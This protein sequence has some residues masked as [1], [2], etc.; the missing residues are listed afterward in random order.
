[1]G[2]TP[3]PSDGLMTG[4]HLRRSLKIQVSLCR[5]LLDQAVEQLTQLLLGFLGA[6]AAQRFEQLGRELSAL[7]QRV[8][9]CLAQSFDG[10]IGLRIEIVEVGIHALAAGESRLQQKIREL[11]KERLE[12]DSI[13]RFRAELRVGVEAHISNIQPG[14]RVCIIL[15]NAPDPGAPSNKID[16][17]FQDAAG[18]PELS[19]FLDR[20]D[21][22]PDRHLDAKCC[23]VVAGLSPDWFFAAAGR[24]GRRGVPVVLTGRTS[25]VVRRS[26][27]GKRRCTDAAERQNAQG[28]RGQNLRLAHFLFSFIG[29]GTDYSLSHRLSRFVEN[30]DTHDRAIAIRHADLR[31]RPAARRRDASTQHGN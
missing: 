8:E 31:L 23:P 30:R 14:R 19:T 13:S 15:S 3:A 28:Q 5:Q 7:D 2:D 21:G 20:S 6:V 9:N 4:R 1:V 17:P 24:G 10:S 12:I 22:L 29:S 26:A 18:P 27:R 25:R 11:V 16:Q